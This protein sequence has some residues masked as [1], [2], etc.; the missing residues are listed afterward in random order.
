MQRLQ[1]AV[2]LVTDTDD[3]RYTALAGRVVAQTDARVLCSSVVGLRA[4]LEL[5]M[6]SE[7]N[8]VVVVPLM[9]GAAHPALREITGVLQWAG[10]QWP[11]VILRSIAAYANDSLLAS[12]LARQLST[13][14]AAAPQLSR[15]QATAVVLAPRSSDADMNAEL[16][17]ATRRLWERSAVGWAETAFL[18]EGTPDLQA[19]LRRSQRASDQAIVVLPLTL[20]ADTAFE[21]IA[22][23]VDTLRHSFAGLEICLAPPLASIEGVAATIGLRVAQAGHLGSDGH[24]HG[25]LPPRYQNGAPVSAAPMPAAELKY[26]PDGRVAWDEIWGDFC[27]LALAGGPPHRGT[28]LEPASPEAIGAD[29]AAYIQVIEELERGLRMVTGLEVLSNSAPGWIGLR[30]QSQEMALWL[31]RAILVENL[32]ARREDA[33]L[34]LPV[35]PQFRLGHE[36]KNVITVVA[37][38]H[39]YWTEHNRV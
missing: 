6:A 38:T 4:S 28:L 23:E 21:R 27:E 5:A 9:L 15:E 30:C 22:A 39:H 13:A 7:P 17:S 18:S 3:D 34:F 14:L 11:R 24:N 32:A 29:P 2:M 10:R 25:L 26:G 20:L 1:R 35:G 19:T 36:I 33:T 8:E 31:L 12:L 37:K 16:W